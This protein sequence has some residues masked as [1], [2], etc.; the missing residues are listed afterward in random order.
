[1]AHFVCDGHDLFK[2]QNDLID[3]LNSTCRDIDE[4][5]KYF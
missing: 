5:L 3:L 2:I 4:T 1:M